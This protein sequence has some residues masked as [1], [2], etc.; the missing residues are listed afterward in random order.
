MGR[1]RTLRRRSQSRTVSSRADDCSLASS[2]NAEIKGKG[3]LFVRC[4][5]L[6]PLHRQTVSCL[7]APPVL[8]DTPASFQIVG[9]I[10]DQAGWE[11][12]SWPR[13]RCACISFARPPLRWA[14]EGSQAEKIHRSSF[15]I[16]QRNTI[17]NSVPVLFDQR[18]QNVGR[19]K[20]WRSS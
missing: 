14:R 20:P 9:A 6:Y 18:A 13:H 11:K 2:R 1:L 8:Q 7:G 16:P 5:L 17:C 15:R 19:P 4:L 3:T 12:E 10:G